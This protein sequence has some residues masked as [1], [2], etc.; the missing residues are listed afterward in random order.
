MKKKCEVRYFVTAV[1]SIPVYKINGKTE[2]YKLAAKPGWGTVEWYSV[3][4][5]YKNPVNR[6][7]SDKT[8]KL[9]CDEDCS[10]N[11]YTKN[12]GYFGI[13][14]YE[15]INTKEMPKQAVNANM[16]L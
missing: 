6:D 10:A 8:Q 3:A 4:D 16:K 11:L 5:G 14:P 9:C 12:G 15:E 13:F 2:A 1:A 7:S